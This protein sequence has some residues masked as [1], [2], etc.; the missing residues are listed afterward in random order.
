VTNIFFHSFLMMTLEFFTAICPTQ[1]TN[2]YVGITPAV[3]T[4]GMVIDTIY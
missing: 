1:E 2:L 3:K 4:N